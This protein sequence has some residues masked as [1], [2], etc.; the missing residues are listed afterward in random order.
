[1]IADKYMPVSELNADHIGETVR[2]L[3][4]DNKIEKIVTGE[5]DSV[6]HHRA[7]V[8]VTLGGKFASDGKEVYQLPRAQVVHLSPPLYEV[9]EIAK[10][11]EGMPR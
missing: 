1:M 7:H 8:L 5:I 2:F 4:C 3:D 6:A 10:L 9:K 11:R